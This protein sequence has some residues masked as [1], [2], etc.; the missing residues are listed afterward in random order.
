VRPLVEVRGRRDGDWL[1]V[2]VSDNGIG[3][4]EDQRDQVFETFHRAHGQG[5]QGTGL[6]LAICRRIADRHGGSIHAESVAT[7]PDDGRTGTT[8]VVRL[9]ATAA[10][11]AAT[12][13]LPRP[14]QAPRPQPVPMRSPQSV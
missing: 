6:G 4:P 14:T 12:P 8:F 13:A 3:I 5:Y 2:R 11:Y 1:E 9:P 10:A 7:S